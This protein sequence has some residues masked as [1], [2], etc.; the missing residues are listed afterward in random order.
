MD[1]R[2]AA[3]ILPRAIECGVWRKRR[4][5]GDRSFAET[6]S[7]G[8]LGPQRARIRCG[9]RDVPVEFRGPSDRNVEAL[10]IIRKT[11]SRMVG[12]DLVGVELVAVGAVAPIWIGS[13]N[14]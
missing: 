8:R 4:M 1:G 3:C 14:V 12:V 9:D 7:V 11:F 2:L 6:I 5:S 13:H 10:D